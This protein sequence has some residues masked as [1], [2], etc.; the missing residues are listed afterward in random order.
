M[1]P[2][3]PHGPGGPTFESA[4][5]TAPGHVPVML[6]EVLQVLAPRQGAIYVDGTRRSVTLHEVAP[7][8]PAGVWH[9]SVASSTTTTRW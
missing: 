6:E 8:V 2:A 1:S 3:R 7:G 4:E 5:G 9:E